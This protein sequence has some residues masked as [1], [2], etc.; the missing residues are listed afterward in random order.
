MP[1]TRWEEFR[2]RTFSIFGSIWRDNGIVR[3]ASEIVKYFAKGDD[4]S[5]L[6]DMAC[7]VPQWADRHVPQQA[8]LEA[9]AH[10]IAGLQNKRDE[11]ASAK[12][13]RPAR[14][15]SSDQCIGLALPAVLNG[16]GRLREW[17]AEGKPHPLVWL[18]D[19][20]QRLHL[21]QSMGSLQKFRRGLGENGKKVAFIVTDDGSPVLQKIEKDRRPPRRIDE[22]E[23]SIR[24]AGDPRISDV[25]LEADDFRVPPLL[26]EN[27][28]LTVTMPQPRF[29]PWAEEII[30]VE[31]FTPNPKT[32]GGALGLWRI[33]QI[34][35]KARARW[36]AAGSPEPSEA[37]AI[38]RAV[39]ADDRQGGT[40]AS[41]G[42][43]PGLVPGG[44]GDGEAGA[45][46]YR[47]HNNDNCPARNS[48]LGVHILGDGSIVDRE[49]GEIVYRQPTVDEM[50][51]FL[52]IEAAAER[53]AMLG[54][55]N[56]RPH[57]TERVIA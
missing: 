14:Y 53:A 3:D 23:L 26:V 22:K 46:P 57:C 12:E 37:L 51:D 50:I 49:T 32:D 4:L 33:Q 47:S 19:Q 42:F 30:Y 55:E 43:L 27:R 28:I 1:K 35:E 36:V 45:G 20:M 34:Q 10:K 31:N 52:G 5:L 54:N 13:G 40:R 2:K 48:R 11:R 9:M 39:R 56:A 7:S 21:A 44:H 17:A 29:S 41:G 8:L 25:V 18:F 38:A 24:D 16:T 15:V 6:A